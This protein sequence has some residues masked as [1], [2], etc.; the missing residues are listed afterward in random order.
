MK[1]S[2]NFKIDRIVFFL[3]LG[4]SLIDLRAEIVLPSLIGDNMVLK[5]KSEV[6]IWGWDTPGT[7]VRIETGWNNKKYKA[8]AG[9]DGKWSLYVSTP[10]AGGP[11]RICIDGS[12]R[13]ELNNVMIGEVWFTSGQSNMGWSIA[14]E[15]N[16][17]NVLKSAEHPDIRMFHVPHQ[18]SDQKDMM[19]QKQ[20]SWKSC[21]A[22]SVKYFSAMSYYFAVFLQEKLNIP[23]GI[24]SASWAGTGIESWLPYDLQESDSKLSNPIDRW[25]MWKNAYSSDSAMYSEKM[26]VWKNDTARG[27]V[28]EPVKM[29]KSVHMIERPHCK[30]GSLYNAM[31][32][33]CMPY[34]ISG[35]IWYQGENSVEWADEY[36]YQ[37]QS[38]IDS[39]RGGFGTDFPVLVGQLTNFN[40]PSA[41][42]AAVV[43][44]AQL[45]AGEKKDT[46]VICT[47]DIGNP[48]D[49][50]PNDKVPFGRRF[51]DIALDKV[52]GKEAPSDYPIAKC[53]LK[54]GNEIIVQFKYAKGLNIKGDVLDDVVVYDTEGNKL[55]VMKT[56]IDKDKLVISGTDMQS[57]VKVSYAVDND[58]KANLYNGENLPA[59]PFILP[60]KQ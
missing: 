46:Y 37:L 23:I 49:V 57:A 15:K 43:R 3:F 19:F 35:L 56:Y 1:M 54:K 16:S 58:V 40:Y 48:N 34:T 27:I 24:I 41:E 25:T 47:I 20:T 29:P 45:K 7:D 42:K 60:V 36:E 51:A 44:A 9:P 2:F 32:Y 6:A 10:K 50:H 31:V 28:K 18:I 8:T 39:W 4:F 14:E 38:L 55:K 13:V 12:T 52:Y 53:A 21:N 30:P 26:L 5:Q 22:K 17:E 11:F 33:P 59:F